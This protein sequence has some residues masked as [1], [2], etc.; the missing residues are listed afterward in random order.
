MNLSRLWQVM[1]T[2]RP[3]HMDEPS[4]P[5]QGEFGGSLAPH[6]DHLMRTVPYHRWVDYVEDLLRRH[7]AQPRRVLDLACGTGKVGAE[8]L[9][10]DYEVVGVDL[11]EPMVGQCCRQKPLLPA[12]VMDARQLGLAADSL[13]LVVSLYDSLNYII[14]PEG[15]QRCFEGV[16]YGLRPGGLF[17][18]DLNTER[19]LR[20]GLFTQQTL[21]TNNPLQHVWKSYWDKHTKICRIDMRFKWWGSG[22]PVEFTEIHYERAYEEKEVRQMLGAAGFASVMAYN[23]Y[24]FSPPTRSSNRV[25]YVAHKED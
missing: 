19:A 6:Y 5:G 1:A 7:D 17:I 24:T 21:G 15:L 12:A 22:K 11:S 25:Y 3:M 9:R 18:F 4:H 2:D 23:A 10:R 16:N 8:M 14:R 13:D 20:I